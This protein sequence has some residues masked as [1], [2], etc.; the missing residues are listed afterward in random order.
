MIGGLMQ[1]STAQSLDVKVSR[2]SILQDNR[3]KI[4]IILENCDGFLDAPDMSEFN[5]IST[6]SRT[7]TMIS[8]GEA[9]VENIKEYTVYAD[10]IGGFMIPPMTA[11]CGEES[12][13]TEPME[14]IIYPNP[15]GV[16]QKDEGHPFQNYFNYEMDFGREQL[17]RSGKQRKGLP[18]REIKRI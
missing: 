17:K 13:A 3:Y 4:S 15:D 5:V 7:S 16:I 18:G 11:T 2:D 14:V 12:L 1:V 8:N 9:S 10:R 6:S